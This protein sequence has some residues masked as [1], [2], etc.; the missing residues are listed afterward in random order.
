MRINVE[1]GC[2]VVYKL[3][4]ICGCVYQLQ[5]VVLSYF[6]FETVTQNKFLDPVIVNIPSL[7]YCFLTIYA[8]MDR[9][10]MKRKYGFD[11]ATDWSFGPEALFDRI[12]VAE[13][14]NNTPKAAIDACLYRDAT[15]NDMIELFDAESCS[16]AFETKKYIHQQYTCYMLSPKEQI[17]SSFRS[18]ESSLRSGR[19]ILDMRFG[20]PL[21]RFRK[22]RFTI[23]DGGYPYISKAY[24]PAFYKA[25]TDK[26]SAH[27]FCQNYTVTTLGYPYDRYTC[28]MEEM[29]HFNCMDKC[30]NR[31]YIQT[32]GRLPFALFHDKHTKMKL[33]SAIMLQ[34]RTVS[35]MLNAIHDTCKRSCPTYPCFF[36]YCITIGHANTLREEKVKKI[37]PDTTIRIE[38]TGQPN[39]FITY[40]PK[41]P[42]LDFIIYIMS[43]LGAWF[44]FVMISC[45][46]GSAIKSW[47]T[48][49]S[50]VRRSRRIVHQK[51]LIREILLQRNEIDSMQIFLN[52]YRLRPINRRNRRFQSQLNTH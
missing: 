24:S 21:S 27:I 48:S 49:I 35:L 52:R 45:N 40:L 31:T 41:L 18:V 5:N 7:H 4:C 46:P 32:F 13:M 33:V 39:A 3:L 22:I 25:I 38:T 10:Y 9:S 30:L 19:V 12:T 44:G 14:L 16:R 34:N 29:E 2:N 36:T 51:N 17:Y 50:N 20:E 23:T 6:S 28:E 47:F 37:S 1:K 15:G 11:T 43:S 26:I 8:A 42:L